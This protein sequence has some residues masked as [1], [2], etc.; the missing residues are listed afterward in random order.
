MYRIKCHPLRALRIY[1]G[2]H[3][4][5]HNITA[6]LWRKLYSL[7]DTMVNAINPDKMMPA[8][9]HFQHPAMHRTFT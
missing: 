1:I 3:I 9:I 8:L 2:F 7:K 6:V 4:T 5:L